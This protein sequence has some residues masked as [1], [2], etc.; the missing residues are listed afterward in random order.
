MSGEFPRGLVE[1]FE[2]FLVDNASGA[3]GLTETVSG[4]AWDI[5]D[6]HGGWFRST[7]S[8]GEGDYSVLAGELTW[9]V[10]EGHPLVM[11]VRL[12]ISDVS[13]AS[14]FVGFTDAVADTGPPIKDEDGALGATAADAFGFLLEGEQDETWQAVAIDTS[15]HETQDPLTDE[16][17]AADG[18]IQTLRLEA[19]PND[20]GTVKYFIDGKLVETKTGWFDSS[21]LYCPVV[22]TD[23][24]AAA[25]NV[26]IDY[27]YVSAPRS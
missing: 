9:E 3:S 21:I 8:T 19:N 4:A 5:T 7:G 15:V 14:V 23:G 10:D 16:A 24:R 11:E 26:D 17:D 2:D 20:S 27:I 12:K 1:F 25:T 22:S 18:V 6:K 13:V